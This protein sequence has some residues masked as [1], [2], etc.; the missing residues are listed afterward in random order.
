M[1]IAAETVVVVAVGVAI[2]VLGAVVVA[3]EEAIADF[4]VAAATTLP[5]TESAVVQMDHPDDRHV[6]VGEDKLAHFVAEVV[7][8]GMKLFETDFALVPQ[9]NH[10]F[11][12]NPAADIHLV[13]AADTLAVDTTVLLVVE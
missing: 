8:A 6:E 11:V 9:M 12:A 10:T 13:A 2:A 5:P 3:V 4:S 7:A 1:D